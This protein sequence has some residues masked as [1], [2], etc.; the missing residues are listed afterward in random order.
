M[1]VRADRLLDLL[2]GAAE[3]GVVLFPLWPRRQ[4]SARRVILQIRKGSQSP[5]LL[6]PGMVL[7][8]EDGQYTSDADAVLRE[9]SALGMSA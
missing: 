9:A 5:L 2:E 6:M 3:G 1:I 8:E 4:E 7:H